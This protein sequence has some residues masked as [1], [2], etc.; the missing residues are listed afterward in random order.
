[1]KPILDSYLT[2][3]KFIFSG[4]CKPIL[5]LMHDCK[6]YLIKLKTIDQIEVS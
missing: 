1:M 6:E 4:L 3:D 5:D 2:S